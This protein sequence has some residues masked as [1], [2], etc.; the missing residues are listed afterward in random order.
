MSTTRH[1][2][3]LLVLG[4]FLFFNLATSKRPT[5]SGT[6]PTPVP[7]PTPIV[8]A[9]KTLPDL[10]VASAKSVM[11]CSGAKSDACRVLD[12]FAS[13]TKLDESPAAGTTK[14][15][16]GQTFAGGGPANGKKQYFFLQIQQGSAATDPGVAKQSVLST[17]G[18]ARWLRPDSASEE[19]DS[20]ALLKALQ[21]GKSAPAGNGAAAY[22]KKPAEAAIWR[23][24]VKSTGTST[25]IVKP[26]EHATY[27]RNSG[28]HVVVIEYGDGSTLDNA[29]GWCAEAWPLK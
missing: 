15:W 7:M 14:V 9:P 8:A 24:M 12:D 2:A 11:G 22:V 6:G 26:G 25:V 4:V 18:T 3:S 1:A 21:A 10:D 19:R 20:A 13:G 28:N 29:K 23:A 16:M 5:G 17:V 27:V